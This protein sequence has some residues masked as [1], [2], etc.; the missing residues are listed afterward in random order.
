MAIAA[1]SL[2]GKLARS[3]LEAESEALRKRM[4]VNGQEMRSEAGIGKVVNG[5]E[6][7]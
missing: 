2:I 6:I 1:R 3:M 7:F 5:L 4:Q